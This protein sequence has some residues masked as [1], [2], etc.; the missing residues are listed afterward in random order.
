MIGGKCGEDEDACE[1]SLQSA[2]N[3][4]PGLLGVRR[5]AMPRGPGGAGRRRQRRSRERFAAFA[6]LLVM[7][8]VTSWMAWSNG[9]GEEWQR[10]K[11]VAGPARMPIYG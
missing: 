9:D 6:A 2:A 4:L 5:A 10:P 8:T 1:G 11:L 3:T 7:A